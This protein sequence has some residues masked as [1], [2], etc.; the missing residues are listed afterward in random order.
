M[1]DNGAGARWAGRAAV[2][3]ATAWQLDLGAVAFRCVRDGDGYVVQQ[4]QGG[5]TPWAQFAAGADATALLR[6]LVA[7]PAIGKLIALC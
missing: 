1:E 3:A 6:Q 2:A 7:L 4:R 5:S